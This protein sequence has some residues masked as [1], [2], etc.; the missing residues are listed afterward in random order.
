MHDGIGHMTPPADT[1]W[2]DNPPQYPGQTV[3]WADTPW[4]T[5]TPWADAHSLGRHP[6][7]RQ[8]PTNG[9]WAGSTHPT[10]MHSWFMILLLLILDFLLCEKR[11]CI[12]MSGEI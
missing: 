2:A 3:P 4:Q 11:C 10:G 6:L 7:G 5:P 1:P 8:P 12:R 9:Q